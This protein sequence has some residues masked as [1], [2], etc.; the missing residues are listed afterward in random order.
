MFQFHMLFIGSNQTPHIHFMPILAIPVSLHEILNFLICKDPVHM[1]VL[2]TGTGWGSASPLLSSGPSLHAN[3]NWIAGTNKPHCAGN[4]L[5]C[6]KIVAFDI[7]QF[8]YI[9]ILKQFFCINSLLKLSS[10]SIRVSN[11]GGFIVKIFY[12][13]NYFQAFVMVYI[14]FTLIIHF[15]G[16]GHHVGH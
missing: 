10:R 11:L 8:I 16:I 5:L 15:S 12:S 2:G 14:I 7:V 3:M 13:Y 1:P 9:Y 4:T 6:C